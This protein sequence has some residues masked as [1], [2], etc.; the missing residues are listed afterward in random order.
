MSR[1]QPMR[2]RAGN[3]ENDNP[4]LQ[5]PLRKGL[6]YFNDVI[7][8]CWLEILETDTPL[9]YQ[10]MQSFGSLACLLYY[11][12]CKLCKENKDMQDLKLLRSISFAGLSEQHSRRSEEGGKFIDLKFLVFILDFYNY[13]ISL[14]KRDHSSKVKV[15]K[16]L[17]IFPTCKEMKY[18]LENFYFHEDVSMRQMITLLYRT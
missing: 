6:A 18:S 9:M 3:V 16:L 13:H 11:R 15:Q 12:V 10:I 5:L 1:L 2:S 7:P 14:A 8:D 17:S 4:N